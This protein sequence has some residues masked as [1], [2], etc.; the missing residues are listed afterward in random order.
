MYSA[1]MPELAKG[2][3]SELYTAFGLVIDSQIQCPELTR[4]HAASISPTSVNVSIRFGRVPERLADPVLDTTHWQARSDAALLRLEEWAGARFLIRN[5]NEIVVETMA[6]YDAAQMR[7]FLL[8][9]AMGMLLMQRGQIPLHANTVVI[10]GVAVAIAGPIGAGKSTLTA[11][12]HALGC[13]FLADDVSAV[14]IVDGMPYVAPGYPRIKLWADSVAHLG[15]DSAELPRIR[16]DV[17]K[18]NVSVQRDVHKAYAPLAALYLLN[19]DDLPSVSVSPPLTGMQKLMTVQE[20]FYKLPFHTAQRLWPQL[21]ARFNQM[22]NHLSVH[23]LV[24]PRGVA[25]RRELAEC[26]LADFSHFQTNQPQQFLMLPKEK[27]HAT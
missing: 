8:G 14:Q 24:R 20:H 23:H 16:A 10:D 3:P 1:H 25:S 5:G 7:I 26:L 11:E 19:E 6:G 22:L 27:E 17:D 13:T 12:L 18:Y 2:H 21:F 4:S 9:S 15:I